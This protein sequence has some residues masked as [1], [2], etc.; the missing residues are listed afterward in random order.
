MRSILL[1]CKVVEFEHTSKQIS[2]YFKETHEEWHINMKTIAIVTDNAFNMVAGVRESEFKQISC[3]TQT[4]QLALKN[5][6]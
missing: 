3:F 6:L 2:A 1:D 5:V 4:M